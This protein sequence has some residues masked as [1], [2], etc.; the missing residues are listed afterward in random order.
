MGERKLSGF[1]NPE[2]ALP[3]LSRITSEETKLS[4]KDQMLSNRRSF[5]KKAA[6]GTA[7]SLEIPRLVS[8][9]FEEKRIKRITLKGGD[10]VLFQGDSI[11]DFHRKRSDNDANSPEAM[12]IGYAAHACTSLLSDFPKLGL[13]IYNRAVSGNKVFQ[14]ADRWEKDTFALKP[15]VLSI[16]VGVNDYWHTL[17]NGYKGTID[18]Y[19]HDYGALLDRTRQRLPGVKLIIGEP[20]AIPG[21]KAVDGSWFPAF[22]A[23]REAAGEIAARYDAV[24]IPYQRIYE[25]ALKLAPGS[26]WT[27]DG[28]HPTMAG[29]GLMAHAWMEALK[30]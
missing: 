22:D 23:Y 16:L 2:S 1:Q 15:D 18:T 14:L 24:F 30:G 9:A 20:Y 8:A 11:T 27:L 7:L 28:V 13:R 10:T 4:N 26:Y 29:A 5:I 17:V 19:R 3:V 25:K 6:L 21:V 12:G